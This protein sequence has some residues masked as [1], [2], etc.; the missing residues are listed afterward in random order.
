MK[1]LDPNDPRFTAKAL[2]EEESRD[3]HPESNQEFDSLLEFAD[4]LK[5]E[6]RA[7]DTQDTLTEEQK[8][9][10]RKTVEPKEKKL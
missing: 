7:Q 6:L 5:S 2:G 3:I 1:P 8:E 10:V 4:T 9:R